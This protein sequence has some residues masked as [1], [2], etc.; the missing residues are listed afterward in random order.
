MLPQKKSQVADS[1]STCNNSHDFKN[2][3]VQCFLKGWE[4]LSIEDRDTVYERKYL[5]NKNFVFTEEVKSKLRAINSVLQKEELRIKF[6][7]EKIIALQEEWT[8]NGI[9]DDYELDVIMHCWNDGFYEQWHP[10]FENNSFFSDYWFH[11]FTKD[12]DEIFYTDNWNKF[13]GRQE[14]PFAKGFHCYTFHHLYDHTPLAWEDILRIEKIW[15]EV[16]VGNQFFIQ[17]INADET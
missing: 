6:Q 1:Q 4:N 14:H 16:K 3:F 13:Q 5:L 2:A 7:S 17:I 10:E 8:S 15:V 9:I 11:H 12:R